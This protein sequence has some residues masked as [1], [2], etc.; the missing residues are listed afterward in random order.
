M[1]SAESE[2]AAARPA[3]HER[4]PGRFYLWMRAF[5]RFA[6]F[7]TMRVKCR[8]RENLPSKGGVILAIT[9]R[10]HLDPVVV[11]TLVD[12]EIGWM[13]RVEFYRQ[14]YSRAF[15]KAIGAFPVD[16]MKPGVAPVR[17]ATRRLRSA[18]VVGI[19]PE[20]EI[21]IGDT[22]VTHGGPIK[23]GAV[24]LAALTGCPIVPVLVAGS[25]KLS[26]PWPWMPAKWGRL[27]VRFGTPMRVTEIARCRA[28]RGAAADQLREQ[29]QRLHREAVAEWDLPEGRTK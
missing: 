21:Q 27:W 8:G 17:E 14:W 18:L 28:G 11:S 29:F 20:G 26:S 24:Y 6:F 4:L 10:S 12:R 9:H 13:A 2:F 25:E 3:G 15:M 7:F 16:R 23:A 1:E 22:R 19:F 5:W